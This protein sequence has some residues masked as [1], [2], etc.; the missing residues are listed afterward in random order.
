VD[1]DDFKPV[2]DTYGHPCGDELLR[3]VARRLEECVRTE[4]VVARLGGDEFAIVCLGLD[5]VEPLARR[6]T[7]ALSRSFPLLSAQVRIGASVGAAT[8]PSSDVR[9]LLPSADAALYRAKR[10]ART[11]THSPEPCPG[12]T[13]GPPMIASRRRVKPILQGGGP[14]RD[15]LVS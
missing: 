8:G 15:R 2:N 11:G 12:R 7:R 9:T 3:A 5:V 1:L 6:I 14:C 10:K 13:E 4:D